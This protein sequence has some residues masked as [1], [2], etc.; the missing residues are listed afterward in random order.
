M[1]EVFPYDIEGDNTL[2]Q[3]VQIRDLYEFRK[4]N[5]KLFGIDTLISE[6]LIKTPLYVIRL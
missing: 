4:I 3:S 6:N 5:W 2:V 1:M